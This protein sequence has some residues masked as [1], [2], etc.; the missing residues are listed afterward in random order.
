[1]QRS[2]L[3]RS[4]YELGNSRAQRITLALIVGLWIAL[5]WWLLLAGGLEKAR[6]YFYWIGV[7][8]N[9]ARRITLGTA[10]SIYYF[11]ILFTEFVLLKR[12][13]SWSEVFTIASWLLFIFLWLGIAGG[14]NPNALGV[15]AS[16]GVVLF[17]VGS[18][19]NSHAEYTRHLWKQQSENR[20]RLYT[21]GL[22]R[23]CR[24]P[25][26]LGDEIS[27]SACV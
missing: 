27:F 2:D 3:R 20:G 25:N 17:L 9:A 13:V 14:T 23:Y 8:G 24:H 6:H 10:F 21:Q 18:W 19:M 1:M 16:A 26:Y 12:G 15:A 4:M 5:A 11:R 7:P 22:F